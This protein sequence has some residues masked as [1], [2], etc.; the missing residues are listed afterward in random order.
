MAHPSNGLEVIFWEVPHIVGERLL[1]FFKPFLASPGARTGP[2]MQ[3]KSI[4][5]WAQSSMMPASQTAADL[6]KK[7][8]YEKLGKTGNPR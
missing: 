2:G 4:A 6:R 7:S 3:P 5:P 1:G 8:R